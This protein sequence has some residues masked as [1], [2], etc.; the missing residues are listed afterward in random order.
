MQFNRAALR[1]RVGN[2]KSAR[3]LHARHL[4]IDVLPRLK[5]HIAIKLERDAQYGGRE[6]GQRRYFGLIILHRMA[7]EIGV[8]IN[9][10]FD[11]HIRFGQAAAG[12]HLALVA[13]HIHQRKRRSIARITKALEH[14]HFAG[15]AS[16]VA[17]GKRQP[18]ALAQRRSQNGLALFHFDHIAGGLNSYLIAHG[19]FPYFPSQIAW[20]SKSGGFQICRFARSPPHI[21]CVGRVLESDTCSQNKLF[22]VAANVGFE[23]PTYS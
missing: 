20:F 6:H 21:N 9:I 12:Q 8:D 14:L 16:A 10:G 11:G 18:H 3:A 15:A 13:L 2:R 1:G 7:G 17:A 19:L 22:R 5:R 23:N 4:Q